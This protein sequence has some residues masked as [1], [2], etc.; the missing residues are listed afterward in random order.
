MFF[1]SDRTVIFLLPSNKWKMLSYDL[2]CP[3]GISTNNA[4]NNADI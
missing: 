4:G 2:H 3:V 1:V